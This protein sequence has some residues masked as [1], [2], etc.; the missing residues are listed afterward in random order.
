MEKRSSGRIPSNLKI[1]LC[2]DHDINTGILSNL[3]DNGMLITTKVCFPLKSQFEILL[4]V[5]EE[6]LKI[7]VRVSRLLKK[8]DVYDGIGVELLEPSAAYLEFLERQSM[9]YQIKEKRKKTFKCSTCS[10]ITF[11]QAPLHCPFCKSAI[12][13]FIENSGEVNMLEDYTSL[14]DFEKTH[15][16]VINIA[17]GSVPEM[18]DRGM[19][20]QIKVGEFP[21]KMDI[22]DHIA[23]IDLYFNDF[24]LSKKC[25]ARLHLNCQ[26]ITPIASFSFHDACSGALTVISNCTAHGSWMTETTI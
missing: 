5:G 1:K 10:H 7:P 24:S 14:T 17:K 9:L 13:D 21:H 6:I 11:K 22:D 3:S 15:F 8:N 16:P 2:L 4:P 18:K 19:H 25:I 12:D 23:F 26:I 20:V